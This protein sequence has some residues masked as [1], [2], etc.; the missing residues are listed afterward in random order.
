MYG[1]QLWPLWCEAMGHIHKSMTK[2]S[3][4]RFTNHTQRYVHVATLET[5][6]TQYKILFHKAR[7]STST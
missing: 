1:S 5:Y 4:A 7:S 6:L 2:R 3:G